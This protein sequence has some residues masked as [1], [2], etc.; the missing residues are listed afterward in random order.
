MRQLHRRWS[1]HQRQ[2]LQWQS[3]QDLQLDVI[4]THGVRFWLV[5][6]E[7]DLCL[8]DPGF[9]VDVTVRSDPTTLTAV[10]MRTRP[11]GRA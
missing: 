1:P 8:S 10:W 7:A 11:D 5:F 6:P 3:L 2:D 9:G 4:A